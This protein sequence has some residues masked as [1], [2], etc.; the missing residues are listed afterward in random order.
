[1]IIREIFEDDIN[2][3]ING[4][5]KVTQDD[6]EVLVQELEEYVITRDLKKHFA[7]FFQNYSQSFQ[8]KTSDIGVWISGF[9]GSGK[10]L[11]S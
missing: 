10:N 5:V 8:V 4:V 9:F 6:T 7:T 11:T 1:M 3:N 2:R